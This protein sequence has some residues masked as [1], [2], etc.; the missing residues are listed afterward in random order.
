MNHAY[1]SRSVNFTVYLSGA[2]TFSSISSV[3]RLPLFLVDW[4]RS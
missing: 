1:G 2:S 3:G 4:K